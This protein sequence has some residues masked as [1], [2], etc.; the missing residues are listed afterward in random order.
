MNLKI[1]G[2]DKVFSYDLMTITRII[3][4]IGMWFYCE[5]SGIYDNATGKWIDQSEILQREE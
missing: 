1:T 2:G 5:L 4:M 3:H